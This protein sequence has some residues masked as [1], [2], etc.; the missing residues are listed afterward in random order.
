[1]TSMYHVRSNSFPSGSHPSSIRIEEELSKMKTWE[2]T[3]IST[4]KSIGTGLS[5]LEDLYICLKDLLN[6]AST[7]KV[8]SNHQGE[9]CM[10]ELLDGSVG[11]LDICG[12]TRNT[13]SQIKE[14]VQA[15]HSAL[16][17][18][19][20]DSC[21][22]KSVAEYNF[23]TRKMKKNAKKLMTS[24]K[25]KESKFGVSL[26]LNHDQD[27]LAVIRVLREVISMN[28]SIF[29]SLL[30]YLVGPASK[31]KA[32]K[33][34]LLSEGT[35]VSKVQTVRERLEALEHAIETLE[36]E[37]AQLS[38]NPGIQIF[39]LRI[40]SVLKTLSSKLVAER[41]QLDYEGLVLHLGPRAMHPERLPCIFLDF[42]VYQQPKGNR[43]QED[44]V[45]PSCSSGQ[46]PDQ[47]GALVA[48][49]SEML[50]FVAPISTSLSPIV[51]IPTSSAFRSGSGS[52]T[53]R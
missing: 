5:L 13:V 51:A 23:F 14:N 37:S 29:Q 36:S 20:G 42:Q 19:K 41:R 27:L 3:S 10:E 46:V 21:V 4:S 49:R 24:L 44:R 53:P 32:T 48:P 26:V 17:R 50:T 33:C 11:I 34:T 40:T 1:M 52:S 43:E 35:N 8:I 31:S 18:R 16:R 39:D 47:G 12:I 25:K 28:I 15:L 38:P 45:D 9:K 22:G 30:Y 7:Q 6:T 2:A